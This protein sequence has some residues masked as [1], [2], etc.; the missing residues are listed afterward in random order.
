[1]QDKP[2]DFEKDYIIIYKDIDGH[3]TNWKWWNTEKTQEEVL[4]K[5]SEYNANQN[6]ESTNLMTAELVTDQLIREICVYKREAIPI[7]D[8]INNFKELQK[9]IEQTRE[10]LEAALADLNRIGEVE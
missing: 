5:I 6:I 3:F 1:M 8:L 2:I 10:Y 7:Y 9:G 4:K